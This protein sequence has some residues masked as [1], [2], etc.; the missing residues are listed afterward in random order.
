MEDNTL[1][2]E[3]SSSTNK[4]IFAD[5]FYNGLSDDNNVDEKE[6]NIELEDNSIPTQEVEESNPVE[7]PANFG[8]L[9]FLLSNKSTQQE[10]FS[11]NFN[12]EFNNNIENVNEDYSN[13]TIPNEEE[14]QQE[15]PLIKFDENGIVTEDNT[16]SDNPI[17]ENEVESFDN[18]VNNELPSDNQIEIENNSF[19]EPIEENIEPEQPKKM[20]EEQKFTQFLLGDNVNYETIE[21]EPEQVLIPDTDVVN[22]SGPMDDSLKVQTGIDK[23]LENFLF[24]RR[25]VA[26]EEKED[27]FAPY[28]KNT[29][30][31]ERQV[32]RATRRKQPQQINT[33]LF[34]K[35]DITPR[36]EEPKVDD[37]KEDEFEDNIGNDTIDNNSINLEPIDNQPEE[38]PDWEPDDTKQ[39]IVITEEINYDEP[40]VY[41]DEDVVISNLLDE[42][43][44]KS[45]KTGKISIL[46]K[47]GDDFCSRNYVTNPAI[48]RE[49]EIK[50]LGLILLTPE[51]SAILVGKPGIGKTSIVE[52]LAYRIQRNKVPN[53]LK[54]YRIIS[55]KTTSLLGTLPSGETRLQTLID[56]IKDLDKIILFVDEIHYCSA[57][58]D[59]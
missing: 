27:E 36:F 24:S 15:E 42:L 35:E 41:D 43:R 53:A 49:R 29:E 5:A 2:N 47:Y 14:M 8:N 52:G 10:A 16:V 7:E 20:T 37:F 23:S 25:T 12:N 11:N 39:P 9:D 58:S 17:I 6:N 3:Q 59:L 28:R 51:K 54:G 38:D 46:A 18:Q 13:P 31:E 57:R 40:V 33:Q 30:P 50:E 22:Y 32:Y 48:G 34:E 26:E 21:K 56:E 45:K 19:N 4:F 1:N 55:V 44:E